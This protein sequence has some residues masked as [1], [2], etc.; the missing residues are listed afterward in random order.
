MIDPPAI[1]YHRVHVRNVGLVAQER[2]P[3]LS[4]RVDA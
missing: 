4:I 2:T 3:G 1:T